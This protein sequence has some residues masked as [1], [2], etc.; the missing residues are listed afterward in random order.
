MVI[1]E[2]VITVVTDSA[3]EEAAEAVEEAVEQVERE[4]AH[5]ELNH[6]IEELEER[7][8][9]AI[10]LEPSPILEP[11]I[12]SQGPI[13]PLFI[14]PGLAGVDAASY[15][16]R[17]GVYGHDGEDEEEEVASKQ[18]VAEEEPA[19]PNPSRDLDTAS[20]GQEAKEQDYRQQENHHQH[21]EGMDNQ[22]LAQQQA[23]QQSMLQQQQLLQQRQQQGPLDGK[24]GEG[25]QV[26][27]MPSAFGPPSPYFPG[28]MFAHSMGPAG[29]GH[30]GSIPPMMDHFPYNALPDP[31][32]SD[33]RRYIYDPQ[34]QYHH[35]YHAQPQQP[36]THT[37]DGAQNS[38]HA[39]NSSPIAGSHFANNG[40]SLEKFS[41]QSQSS[42]QDG[43]SPLH[44]SHEQMMHQ[45]QMGQHGPH[46]SFPGPIYYPYGMPA[47]QFSYQ[48]PAGGH[49]QRAYFKPG[50]PGYH[51]PNTGAHGD[52]QGAGPMASF[53]NSAESGKNQ[54]PHMP[55][56][57]HQGESN[58]NQDR[59]SGGAFDKGQQGQ[60]QQQQGQQQQGQQ[61]QGQQDMQK[62]A[63]N[64]M[65]FGAAFPFQQQPMQPGM[66]QNQQ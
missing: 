27:H 12:V 1:R 52:T 38:S 26:P 58:G 23:Y 25:M 37:G 18:E 54:R 36:M 41:G 42:Q 28:G 30:P 29:A 22:E 35:P 57:G 33:M 34:L 65:P 45:S 55:L 44:A 13:D 32:L 7:E 14:A 56:Y 64:A 5:V 20:Q 17:F 11:T 40:Q 53:F 61:G 31:S 24:H 60:G 63:Y 3:L 66:F 2:E 15:Q 49:M 43:Q 16:F 10:E 9:E 46:H 21:I 62:G 47:A 39:R 59:G 4:M 6:A 8:N 51:A 50:S 19:A 48:G